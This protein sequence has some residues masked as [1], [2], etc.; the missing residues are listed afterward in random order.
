MRLLCAGIL[1]LSAFTSLACSDDPTDPEDPGV[2]TFESNSLA[3]YDEESDDGTV[4]FFS[5]SGGRLVASG[6]GDARH[7][8]LIRRGVTLRDGRV[9]VDTDH[10]S[11]GLVVFR[12]QDPGTFYYIAVRDD[13]VS[14]PN[15]PIRNIELYRV[16]G[17]EET[18]LG[19]I[20]LD[21][22]RSAERA[23]GVEFAGASIT[24]AVDGVEVGAFEDGLIPAA[25]RIGVGHDDQLIPGEASYFEALRWGALD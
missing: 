4:G 6:D 2:D 17:G 22:P 11:N 3:A 21:F 23:V 18:S 20:D 24:I 14:Y 8:R 5:I 15:M 16:L 25:G 12:Y 7:A 1:T 9:E 13:E 19:S 10:I